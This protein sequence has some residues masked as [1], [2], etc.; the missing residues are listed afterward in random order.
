MKEWSLKEQGHNSFP[1]INIPFKFS[2]IK[3]KFLVIID[4]CNKYCE[5][6]TVPLA[7]GS[8][9]LLPQN[10]DTIIEKMGSCN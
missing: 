1:Q 3:H 6:Y 4:D 2:R 9:Q 5:I 8:L 10:N 7:Y